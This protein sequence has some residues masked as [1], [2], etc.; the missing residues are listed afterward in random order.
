MSL[1]G[2]QLAAYCGETTAI[3]AEEDI[4]PKAGRARKKSPPSVC[5]ESALDGPSPR[6]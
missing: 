2:D 3:L 1:L 4:A 6:E 5:Q